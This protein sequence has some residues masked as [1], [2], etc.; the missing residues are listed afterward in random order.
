[1]STLT[2]TKHHGLGNDFLVAF[3]PAVSESELPDL[4]RRLCDR[5]RGLGADGLL[6]AESPPDDAD[7]STHYAATMTLFNADG[8]RA[9]MS[10][11][12][13]RCFVQALSM[14]H[15]GD[16]STVTIYTDAGTR[17]VSV[18]ATDDPH[19]LLATVDMG[20]VAPLTEPSGWGDLGCHPDRPVAHLSMGNPHS[21]VGVDDV[22][23]VDLAQLGAKVPHINLEI[24]EPCSRTDE[25]RMRVHERGAGITEACGTGACASAFAA[26]SW[27]LATPRD[28]KLVVHMDGG[29]ATVALDTPS[30]GRVTLTGPATYVATIDVS[31]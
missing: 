16:L 4:A 3:H 5:R 24:I 11:N 13:I 28:G 22:A 19:T 23:A 15:D 25:I 26:A 14:R 21:V 10:G 20:T 6:V 31:I 12:G 29:S 27:G 7:R 8:S 18:E 17:V 1:M 30:D 9:E 2:L